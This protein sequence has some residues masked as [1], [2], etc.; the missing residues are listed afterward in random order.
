MSLRCHKIRYFGHLRNWSASGEGRR[1]I[2]ANTSQ[3]VAWSARLGFDGLALT[4]RHLWLM[5]ALVV[6][7]LCLGQGES[8]VWSQEPAGSQPTTSL[9]PTAP[10]GKPE[11]AG[12]PADIVYLPGADG[13]LVPVPADANLEAYLEFLKERRAPKK[14]GQP[15]FSVAGVEFT[16]TANE[17][18]VELEG[19]FSVQIHESEGAVLVPLAVGEALLRSSAYEGPG[20]AIFGGF[21]REQGYRWWFRGKGLH[22]LTL[23]LSVP[24]RKQVAIRRLQ[25]GIPSAAVSHLKL[26]APMSPLVVKASEQSA[27]ETRDIDGTATEIDVFGLGE[28]IDLTWQPLPNSQRAEVA[29]ETST[30]IMARVSTDSMVLEAT[31]RIRALQSTFDQVVVRLPVGAEIVAIE[32]KEYREHRV[33][34][35]NPS[36]VTLLLT[37]PSNGIAILNWTVRAKYGSD[38]KIV[39][40]GFA[41]E[42]ARKQTG[43]VGIVPLEGLRLGAQEVLDPNIVRISAAEWRTRTGAGQIARAYRF[44]NQPFRLSIS[45]ETVQPYFVV[46]PH[47]YLLAAADQ[48]RLEAQFPVQVFRGGVQELVLR[49]P[50]WREA[51]W[52]IEGIEPRGTVVESFALGDAA[53]PEQLIR[54]RL[55]DRKSDLVTV[56]LRARRP[57]K[58][59]EE[60]QFSLPQMLASSPLPTSL[61]VFN[62]E[63]VE[64]EVTAVGSTVIRPLSAALRQ[65]LELPEGFRNL[66]RTDYRVDPENQLVR[67]KVLPQSQKI[68]IENQFLTEAKDGQLNVL[69]RLSYK[70][71][72]ERLLA[73]R[74]KVPATLQGMLQVT[75]EDKVELPIT[76]SS[77]EEG[78]FRTARIAL[79]EPRLGSFAVNLRYSVPLP[80]PVTAGA[81]VRAAVPLVTSLDAEPTGTTFQFARGQWFATTTDAERWVARGFDEAGQR[82]AAV[83]P[84]AEFPIKL[85]PALVGDSGQSVVTKGLVRGTVDNGGNI[86]YAAVFRVTGDMRGVNVSLPVTVTLTRL[87]IGGVEVPLPAMRT[88]GTEKKFTLPNIESRPGSSD[89]LIAFQYQEPAKRSLSWY[90]ELQFSSPRFPQSAWLAQV[91]WEVTLPPD[92]LLFDHSKQ[93]MP[94]F[95]WRP[96]GLAFRRV[97]DPG[98][99]Q[100]DDWIGISGSGGPDL[101]TLNQTGNTYS[102]TQFGEPGT[103]SLS[104]MS[105]PM[106]LFIGAGSSLLMGFL[107]LKVRYLRHVITVL[108]IAFGVSLAGL[109]Y[110]TPLQLLLQPMI[111]GLVFPMVAVL[112]E[113]RSRWQAIPLATGGP[114]PFEN[115]MF[116]ETLQ[117]NSR[118]SIVS[119]S[120]NEQPTQL[121]PIEAGTLGRTEAGSGI[122]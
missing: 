113:L 21:D 93:V 19:V 105:S 59:N 20:D 27:T 30:S 18:R 15:A 120:V 13:Q 23:G 83:A 35:E 64:S 60:P 16:G 96:A 121:R 44:L 7:L 118:S 75:S 117:R 79:D 17:E 63:K 119:I 87:T 112:I 111:I 10:K 49:W 103:L 65:R 91:V 46:E 90:S 37:A 54:I 72:Y 82:W 1:F 108:L 8:K 85:S 92:L 36:R 48:L 58:P 67:V 94:M 41:V 6:G 50:D 66:S 89:S 77:G 95:R 5:L 25:L 40:E 22:Q 38:K 62:D 14:G 68:A 39:L 42:G 97:S 122:S 29:L 78:P 2:A 53:E 3:Q 100:L 24:L 81:E 107:V 56:T 57:V 32:G 4:P 28:R 115:E 26:T 55:V 114:L 47:L 31:Q 52:L 76:W 84:V 51:G 109:W 11:P 86:R 9:P 33:D 110:M 102:L 45:T 88:T 12:V 34:P 116:P 80:A 101:A 71:A 61:L 98:S 106:I 70:V 69:Q 99:T 104:A 43:E 73:L 74:L